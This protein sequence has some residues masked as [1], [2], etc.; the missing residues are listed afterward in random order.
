MP[1]L[2][3]RAYRLPFFFADSLYAKCCPAP[4]FGDVLALGK[5]KEVRIDHVGMDGQH[6]VRIAWID[7]QCAVLQQLDC[8][9]RCVVDR[10]HLVIIAL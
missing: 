10:H 5:R 2:L 3:A 8:Q 6:S 9:P 4:P 7:L 1:I